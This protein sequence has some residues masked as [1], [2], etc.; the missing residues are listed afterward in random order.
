M[1]DTAAEATSC[2]TNLKALNVEVETE[3]LYDHGS[4]LPQRLATAG[5][6]LL[7]ADGPAAGTQG[8]RTP[9]DCSDVTDKSCDFYN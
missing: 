8:D 3:G 6:Q 1:I 2:G 5:A 9:Y 4:A 7:P